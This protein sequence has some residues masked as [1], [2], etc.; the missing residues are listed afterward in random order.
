M[1]YETQMYGIEELAQYAK[2]VGRSRFFAFAKL[3]P[4]DSHPSNAPFSLS[5]QDENIREF[6]ARALW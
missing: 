1:V 5:F 6:R 2:L 3:L 4:P